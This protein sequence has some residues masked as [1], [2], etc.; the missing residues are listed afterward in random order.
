MIVVT[1]AA[2]FIGSNLVAGL[3]RRGITDIIAVD[4]LTDGTKFRNLAD[5]EIADYLDKDEFLALAES[6]ELPRNIEAVF[7]QGA[8]STTTEWNGEFMME[9]NYRYSKV[10]LAFCQERRIPFIYAS[11]AS[12]YG[13]GPKYVEGQGAEKPL[14]LYAYSKHLFDQYVRRLKT[15]AAQVAGLRYFNVYGPREQ[16]KAGMA[17]TAFHFN[18][19]VEAEGECRLFAG[20][21]GYA[22]GEQRRD[23]VYVEDIVDLNLWLYDHPNITGV[24][25]AGTGRSQ[26]FNDVARAVIAWHGK[27][28]I[29]YIPFPDALKGRYQS[30]TEANLEKLRAA[31]YS[32]EFLTVEQGVAKYL[33]W[34]HGK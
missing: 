18:N 8:C 27:G 20:C 16:H 34:L 24:F 33:D 14:N 9:V 22:D 6:D 2:G 32:K 29:K 19:Q 26:S 17:S 15:P 12:V 4:D 28:K 3:N 7:H 31:G 25:N 23:F 10:M 11:S 21:D 13:M 30:F 1:G 5:L